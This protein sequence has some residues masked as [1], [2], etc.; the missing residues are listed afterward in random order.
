METNLFEQL[1]ELL[2]STKS[3]AEKF[4]TKGNKSANLQEHD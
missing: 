4:Y 3:D 2:E 1:V